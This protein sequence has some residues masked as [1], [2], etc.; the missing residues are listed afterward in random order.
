[1]NSWRQE[2]LAEIV[3]SWK[4][5]SRLTEWWTFMSASNTATSRRQCGSVSLV[6]AAFTYNAVYTCCSS[7]QHLLTMDQWQQLSH[8]RQ[9]HRQTNT[10]TDGRTDGRTRMDGR[11]DRQ[12][13]SIKIWKNTDF[14]KLLKIKVP[15]MY[16]GDN[17]NSKR[18][19]FFPVTAYFTLLH[20]FH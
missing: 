12:T 6:I 8:A 7:W 1:M 4:S 10:K 19:V 20:I 18:W 9:T 5:Y 13:D 17:R 3:K 15:V 16:W 11:T 2:R 14:Q